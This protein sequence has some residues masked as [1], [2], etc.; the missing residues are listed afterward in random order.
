M[1]LSNG[2]EMANKKKDTR[3]IKSVLSGKVSQNQ[4]YMEY[5]NK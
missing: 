2:M 5:K 3:Q 1:S 4:I